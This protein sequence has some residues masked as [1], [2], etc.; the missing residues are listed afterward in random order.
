[1]NGGPVVSVIIPVHNRADRVAATLE[2]VRT[3]RHRPIQLILVDD[4]STDNS[5]QVIDA[6]LNDHAAEFGATPVLIRQPNA[7]ACAARNAGLRAMAGDYVQFLDSDD[8]L[9]ANKLSTA[10]SVMEDEADVDLVSC[11]MAILDDDTGAQRPFDGADLSG[12]PSPARIALKFS[13]TMIP[14][15]RAQLIRQAGFWNERLLALQ[16]WEYFA[17]IFLHAK[18]G[19]HIPETLCLACEHGGIRISRSHSPS[20]RLALEQTR[21]VAIRSVL[22]SVMDSGGDLRAERR[23]ARLYASAVLAVVRLGS[24]RIGKEELISDEELRKTSRALSLSW[25]GLRMVFMLP[26]ALMSIGIRGI[27]MVRQGLLGFGTSR[28]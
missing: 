12:T 20:R 16:D 2:S 22:A 10:V 26:P 21:L 23:L 27:L 1:M 3:Q 15:F 4:G 24:P 11:N 18:R 25:I 14:V 8:L 17:R 9:L 28:H 7:G 5:V 19:V 13:Q 6:W